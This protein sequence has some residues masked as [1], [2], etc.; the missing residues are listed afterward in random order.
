MASTKRQKVL[1]A[2]FVIGLTALIVDRVWLRP[3]AASADSLAG[4]AAQ[5]SSAASHPSSQA[6]PNRPSVAQRLESLWPDREPNFSDVRD[7]F[8]LPRSW[9]G[10]QKDGSAATGDPATA[11][12]AT[13]RL[14]AVLVEGRVSYALVGD[15]FLTPGQEIDG[16][17]L[18][19]VGDRFAVFEGQGSRVV[20]KLMNE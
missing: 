19:S 9:S 10:V 13:H 12:A 18:V 15:R 14:S 8:C 7:P 3:K 5:A 17:K 20:L 4:S 11:F 6:A 16:F 2:V 1:V